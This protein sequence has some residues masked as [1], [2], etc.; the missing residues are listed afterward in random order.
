ME[1]TTGTLPRAVL[2]TGASTGIGAASALRLDRLGWQVFA[3]VRRE[4]DGDALRA[5][6]SARMAPLRLDITDEATISAAV[7]TVTASVGAAGLRGLVNNAGIAVAGPL[8]FLPIAALRHQLEVNV[9]G[10]IAVTRAL[11]PLLRQ[12]HGRIVNIGSVS[13]RVSAPFVGP[14]SA[15]KFALDALTTTL[16]MELQPWRIPVSIIEPGAIATPIW[17][18]SVAAADQLLDQL[19]PQAHALYGPAMARMRTGAARPGK[20]ISVDRV[21]HAVVH[22]L[23]SDKPRRRY[24]VGWDARLGEIVRLLPEGPRDWLVARQDI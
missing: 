23:T 18:K 19:P 11:L 13:G 2:V 20:G 14:Y 15:S 9:I 21:V 22:A 3:G 16:R 17:Q 1:T 8:E 5:K 12:D 24:V 10:Q 4:A 7:E 6:A